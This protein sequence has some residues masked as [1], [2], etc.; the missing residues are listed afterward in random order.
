VVRGERDLAPV[1]SLGERLRSL[2]EEAGLTQKQLAV[3]LGGE[4]GTMVSMWETAKRFPPDDRLTMYARLFATQRS[5]SGK[6][7]PRLIDDEDMTEEEHRRFEQLERELLALRD[8]ARR[9]S[10]GT[11]T[12]PVPRS[13]SD[14]TLRSGVFRFNDEAMITVIC[15]D[16]PEGQRPTFADPSN[17]NYVRAS[18]F[19]DLD[20]LLDLFGHLRA[21]NPTQQV[22][23][24]AV[25]ELKKEEMSGHLVLLGGS[26]WNEATVWLS[27][28]IGLPLRQ[29]TADEE[30]ILV[31]EH[32]QKP[33]QFRIRR[34]G[35]ALLED[36]GVF[37]RAPN[38]QDPQYT[39][40]ICNGITTRGVRGA[41]QCFADYRLGDR[42]E[43]YMATRFADHSSYG[44]VV[45][46][47]VLQPSG[48]PLTPDLTKV[49]TR[50]HEWTNGEAG[51]EEDSDG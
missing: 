37:V 48:E 49:R 43:R 6:G 25:G 27:Q 15:A 24:R 26:V 50:L 2:R 22:R 35:D 47:E 29:D 31:L 46:V 42:N 8:E 5:F 18:S 21:E 17:L 11:R 9:G 34:D 45:R 12:A 4:G 1:G 28:Q 10:D 13:R 44:I 7:P 33:Q 51:P 19:A 20:A 16:V 41:V 23:I 40:T 39:I 36:V 14:L 32:A 38:P 30:E 3:V